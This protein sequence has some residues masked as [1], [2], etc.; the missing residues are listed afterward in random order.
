MMHRMV[1][2]KRL[3]EKKLQDM[4]DRYRKDNTFLKTYV[5]AGFKSLYCVL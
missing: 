5:V 1:E 4:E 3:V 2:E